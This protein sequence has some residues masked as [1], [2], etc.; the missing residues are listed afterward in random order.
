LPKYE[1]DLIQGKNPSVGYDKDIK[2]N[3]LTIRIQY[4]F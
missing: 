3:N 2:D 4:K 1:G